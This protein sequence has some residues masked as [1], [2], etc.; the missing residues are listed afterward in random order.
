MI[1]RTA[2]FA[3]LLHLI[4]MMAYTKNHN[5]A[6]FAYIFIIAYNVKTVNLEIKLPD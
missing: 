3:C 1:I 5:K 4:R 2:Y 6:S